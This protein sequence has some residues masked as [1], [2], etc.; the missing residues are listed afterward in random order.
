MLLREQIARAL[1]AWEPPVYSDRP[2][3][4]IPW[5]GLS[6]KRMARLLEGADRVLAG[7]SDS[8]EIGKAGV[9]GFDIGP[10]NARLC[11]RAI[12]DAAKEGKA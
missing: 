7:L 11:F 4:V 12:V 9:D 8:E 3:K 2:D 10:W 6:P 5:D 1:Y